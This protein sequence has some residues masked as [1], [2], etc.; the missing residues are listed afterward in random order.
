VLAP[1]Q[2]GSIAESA[3]VAAAMK[4]GVSVFKPV[5]EGL[6]YDLIFELGYRL[7]RVQCKWATRRG[8]VIVIPCYS[9]RRARDGL[10]HRKYTADEVDAIAAYCRDTER[11]DFLPI[12]SL[13]GQ[14]VVDLRLEAKQSAAWNH[15]GE[16]I[17]VRGYTR[18]P[19]G[20]SSAGR[21]RAWHARGHGFEPRRLHWLIRTTTRRLS[22]SCPT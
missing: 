3:I 2:K 9:C 20:R 17:Q 19:R 4:L 18:C 8:D 21:A 7:L 14:G 16:R 11:C 22:R 15:V 13:C 10:R 12:E 6:R 1:S 5:N